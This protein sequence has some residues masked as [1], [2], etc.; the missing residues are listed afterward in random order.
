MY[1]HLEHRPS[2]W[3]V[4]VRNAAAARV[5]SAVRPPSSFDARGNG[6]VLSYQTCK[7]SGYFDV[8]QLTGKALSAMNDLG[9]R[10]MHEV[11]I[12]RFG[13]EPDARYDAVVDRI[14]RLLRKR[15]ETFWKLGSELD[16]VVQDAVVRITSDKALTVADPDRFI[17]W[18]FQIA[19][20]CARERLRRRVREYVTDDDALQ[21]LEDPTGRADDAVL[22]RERLALLGMVQVW[23]KEDAGGEALYL[24]AVRGWKHERIAEHLGLSC[25]AV[26]ALVSR[27]RRRLRDDGRLG[28]LFRDITA[29]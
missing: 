14:W 21:L 4:A 16:D 20:N 2:V 10:E 13:G 15:V 11:V 5:G 28:D 9:Q 26:R 8:Q 25:D 6:R 24:H 19:V 1:H 3:A 12:S 22:M 18:C 17:Y 7:G 29:T 27:A 23:M